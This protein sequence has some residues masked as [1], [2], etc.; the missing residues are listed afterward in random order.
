MQPIETSV[1]PN[2][3]LKTSWSDLTRIP[4]PIGVWPFRGSDWH[5]NQAKSWVWL[6]L[7]QFDPCMGHVDTVSRSYWPRN[8]SDPTGRGS[9]SNLTREFLECSLSLNYVQGPPDYL[10]HG[11]MVS[12]S[13][14]SRDRDAE[15][16]A[17]IFVTHVECVYISYIVIK[18]SSVTHFVRTWFQCFL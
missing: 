16:P 2:C 17:K 14:R 7:S 8:E 1:M 5:E 11:C 13:Q 4:G 9:G 15:V 6:I 18:S 3:T 12:E 10:S